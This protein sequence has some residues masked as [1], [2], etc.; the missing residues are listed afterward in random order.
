[1]RR[2][3]PYTEPRKPYINLG[4]MVDISLSLLVIFILAIPFF[5]ESGL[6]VSKAAVA[7]GKKTKTVTPKK[8]DIKVNI[9]MK[10]DGTILLNGEP[11]TM[12]ELDSLIPQLLARSVSRNAILSAD[13]DVI[14]DQVIHMI[15]F[16]KIKGA[17][18]VLIVKRKTAG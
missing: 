11:R 7:K 18:D 16:L 13:N 5:I 6:F 1:M 9:Y 8:S 17:E 15:D 3:R 14:Y 4:P 2:R 10:S 12:E